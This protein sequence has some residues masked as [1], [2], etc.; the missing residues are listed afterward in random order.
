ML[1]NSWHHKLFICVFKSGKCEKGGKKLHEYL[2][3]EKSFSDKIKSIF[4]SF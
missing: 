2:E 1:A 4:Y 3:N